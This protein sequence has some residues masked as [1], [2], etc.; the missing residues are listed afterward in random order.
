MSAQDPSNTFDYLSQHQWLIFDE[1]NNP[2]QLKPDSALALQDTFIR[3]LPTQHQR[4]EQAGL[5]RKPT[6]LMHFYPLPEDTILLG[7]K[8]KRLANFSE[9]SQF[10]S[11]KGYRLSVRP[12]GGLAVV[13]DPG[14]LNF[15]LVSDNRYFPLSI[16]AAY[17]QMVQLV[18]LTLARYHLTVE[19]YE[20][21][22]S[23]CPGRYDLV[24]NGLKIGGIAQRR[25]KTGITCAAY[26]SVNGDQT[27]RAELIRSFYQ[28]G[29][30]DDTYPNVN[31]KVMAS[32]TDLLDLPEDST[33]GEELSVDQFKADLL[34]VLAC[35]SHFESGDFNDAHLQELYAKRYEATYNRSQ[36]AQPKTD[37]NETDPLN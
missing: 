12:H 30:A 1:Q 33:A 28:I 15:A 13:V 25:F 5:F 29:Q 21:V 35:S 14:V 2:N 34:E 11:D 4:L 20:I 26:I 3:W 23:Y 6:A 31:P 37:K 27:H 10:L 9:A 36:S 32:L 8:D 19:S 22:D 18:G 7:A 17:E 16:D 24:V